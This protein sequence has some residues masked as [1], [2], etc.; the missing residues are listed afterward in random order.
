MKIKI[1]L[2][3]EFHKTSVKLL[4]RLK[5][6]DNQVTREGLLSV[7]QVKRARKVLCGIG[8]CIC[9]RVAGIRGRQWHDG[10]MMALQELSD[11]GACVTVG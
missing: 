6:S 2:T 4:I 3:N 8:S 11:G 1:E 9:W 5:L 7:D 10:N